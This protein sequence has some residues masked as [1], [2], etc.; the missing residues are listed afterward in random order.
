MHV[1]AYEEK[2]NCRRKERVRWNRERRGRGPSVE[3]ILMVAPQIHQQPRCTYIL[4]IYCIYPRTYIH[5][6][7]ADN[8]CKAQMSVTR[9][10]D[11]YV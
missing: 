5:T 10:Y 6:Y 11:V 7:V 4:Y 3:L 2:S 8:L 1:N 9:V